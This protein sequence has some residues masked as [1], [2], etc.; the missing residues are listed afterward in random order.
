MKN[1]TCTLCCVE[2]TVD[3]FYKN[4]RYSDGFMGWCKECMKEYARFRVL[5]VTPD[6]YNK[7]F[8]DQEGLCWICG[9]H[10]DV[11][12]QSLC[13][14]HNHETGSIRGLLCAKCNRGIGF[15]DENPELLR[16]AISY[17]DEF[18]P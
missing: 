14:D 17:L 10:N 18:T 15:F 7:M 11:L 13:V 9:T 16:A 4:K 1:K 12:S 6:E 3:N 2:K 5:G 8:E